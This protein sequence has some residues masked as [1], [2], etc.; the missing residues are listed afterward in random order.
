MNVDITPL[1]S[2]RVEAFAL[3]FVRITTL[4]AVAPIFGNRV[5][6]VKIRILVGLVLAVA[7]MPLVPPL[8]VMQ[9][10]TAGGLGFLVLNEVLLGLL[11]GLV[12]SVA[13]FGVVV[14]GQ[15]IGLQMGFGI[16]NVIDPHSETQVA[17]TAEFQNLLFLLVFITLNGHHIVIRTLA[18]TLERVP[19]GGFTLDARTM[20]I[21]ARESAEIFSMALRIGAPVIAFLFVTSLGLGIIARTVPQLNVFVLGFP[22]QIAGGL[23]VLL[24]ALPSFRIVFEELTRQMEGNLLAVV[25]AR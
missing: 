3:L 10:V 1:I 16:V 8:P 4:F 6:P 7:L 15:L 5:I 11:L 19:L 20:E 2:G 9:T 25:G 14:A 12:A 18:A 21:A 24:L 23:V 13:F 22:L 17:V